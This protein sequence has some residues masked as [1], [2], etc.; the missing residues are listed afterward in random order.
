MS[1][2]LNFTASDLVESQLKNTD[3]YTKF[4][5]NSVKSTLK[6]YAEKNSDARSMTYYNE[7]SAGTFNRLK[8]E[9]F[10]VELVSDVRDGSFYKISW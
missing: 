2:E 6:S 5:Y 1:T 3:S 4:T 9:G 10:V 8:K 7:L